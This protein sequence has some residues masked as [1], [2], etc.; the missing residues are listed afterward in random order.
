MTAVLPIGLV[1]KLVIFEERFASIL[2]AFYPFFF[3]F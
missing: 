3:F 1:G 2:K